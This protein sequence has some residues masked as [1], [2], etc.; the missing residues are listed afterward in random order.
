MSKSNLA[1]LVLNNCKEFG[2]L[3]EK[4]LQKIRKEKDTKYIIP[5]TE[6]RFSNGEGKI[7]ID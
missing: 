4:N 5:I 3:V 2:E 6:T 7:T 1:L